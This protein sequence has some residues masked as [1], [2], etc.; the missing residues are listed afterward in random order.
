MTAK[1]AQIR[2]EDARRLAA[3]HRIRVVLTGPGIKATYADCAWQAAGRDFRCSLRVPASARHGRKY[4]VTA[5]EKPGTGFV[6]APAI[7][8]A[9][10]PEVFYL[11]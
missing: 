11:R 8:R 7:G 5:Q 3:Q 9:R 4:S 6:T 10:D 2:A 1:G